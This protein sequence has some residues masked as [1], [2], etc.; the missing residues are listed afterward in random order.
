MAANVFRNISAHVNEVDLLTN[1]N[2]KEV[3]K[4]RYMHELSNHMFIRVDSEHSFNELD[5][6]DVNLDYEI[7]VVS[8]YNKG[9]LSKEII[10]NICERHDRVFLDTKKILGP[11]AE[12]AAFIKINDY[13]YKNSETRLNKALR[14]KIIH[15]MGAKGCEYQGEVFPVKPREVRD[16]SGAGD[17]FMAALVVK[18]LETSDIR[19]SIEYANQMASEVVQHRGV[20]II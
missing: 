6:K 18:Y 7:I 3:T 11:W 12:K 5:I 1:P 8:D 20:G 19:N 14:D 17:S 2:Y 4:T 15:T 9:F 13:E 16:T 10:Q